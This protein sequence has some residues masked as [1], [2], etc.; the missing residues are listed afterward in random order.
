M[1]A[2]VLAAWFYF[3]FP[4]IVA[5][6]NYKVSFH[7]SISFSG[8][9]EN[10]V[11]RE[12]ELKNITHFLDFSTSD[13]RLVSIV[14]GPG[15]GKSALAKSV[16]HELLFRGVTIYYVDMAEV[17]SMQAL[18][19]KVLE[20]DKGIVTIRSITVDRMYKWARLLHY[21]T[22]LLLDNCDDMMN[23]EHE[24]EKLQNVVEELLT[25][26]YLKILS[27]SRQVTMLSIELTENLRINP[28]KHVTSCTLIKSYFCEL[29]EKQCQNIGNLTG[30]VPLAVKVV[31]SLLKFTPDPDTIIDRLNKALIPTLSTKKLPVKRRIDSCINISYEYLSPEVKKIGHCLVYFSGSFTLSTATRVC[32]F[33]EL[34]QLDVEHAIEDLVERSLLYTNRLTHSSGVYS[35]RRNVN[36][37]QFHQLIKAFFVHMDRSAEIR[38]TFSSHFVHFF[39]TWSLEVVKTDYKVALE[40][41]DQERHNLVHF[42]QILLE[43]KSIDFK[44]AFL[45]IQAVSQLYEAALLQY[46]FTVSEFHN[47]IL[48]MVKYLKTHCMFNNEDCVG[49]Y[50]SLVLQRANVIKDEYGV[51]AAIEWLKSHQCK[52]N[53]LQKQMPIEEQSSLNL[54]FS[55]LASLHDNL[56]DYEEA[57][58]YHHVVV[59]AGSKPD[60]CS[61]AT[62]GCSYYKLDNVF[63]SIKYLELSLERDD[64]DPIYKAEV[65][66]TLYNAHSDRRKGDQVLIKLVGLIPTLMLTSTMEIFKNF[67]YV[68]NIVT[69]LRD[70]GY[71]Y[72]SIALEEKQLA[73]LSNA[74][75]TAQYRS[76]VLP[77]A[78]FLT[79]YF[80]N[81]SKYSKCVNTAHSVLKII[82]GETSEKEEQM[83]LS[84][85]KDISF[86]TIY[87]GNLS[88]ALDS[89]EVLI[90]RIHRLNETSK[91]ADALI[92]GCTL[93]TLRGSFGCLYDTSAFALTPLKLLYSNR[94]F[95]S[96]PSWQMD[97]L[98]YLLIHFLSPGNTWGSTWSQS[99]DLMLSL[100][101]HHQIVQYAS[102]TWWSFWRVRLQSIVR[103]ILQCIFRVAL[104]VCYVLKMYYYLSFV[105]LCTL[106]CLS[107][108]LFTAAYFV[109][110]AY[111]WRIIVLLYC[112][113]LVLF[114]I[115]F[116]MGTFFNNNLSVVFNLLCGH[117]YLLFSFTSLYAAVHKQYAMFICLC[118]LT[119]G[120]QF[121]IFA[122]AYCNIIIKVLFNIP[123][124]FLFDSVF[125]MIFTIIYLCTI[126][127]YP[128]FLF[129]LCDL[130]SLLL[131]M[132]CSIIYICTLF[133]VPPYLILILSIIHFFYPILLYLL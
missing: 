21:N 49:T 75:F 15:F 43:P 4:N 104:V 11:G 108:I 71:Y 58:K 133:N 129:V 44:I 22:L 107:P 118:I 65:L 33:S 3:E 67:Y 95:P 55:L 34:Q 42:L 91:H 82:I 126:S 45:G 106:H 61:Y 86:C 16:A 76:S 17:S 25:S 52:V 102:Q 93:L 101:L 48:V 121:N 77:K 110:T 88:S 40:W 31:A 57:K 123:W 119:N 46:R 81:T 38:N 41:I 90:G 9:P 96:I 114:S 50:V 6:Y 37:Y 1:L 30:N 79:K 73:A 109:H 122:L 29:T 64:L 27:T 56:G 94:I 69:F 47:T 99:T 112:Q 39:A 92:M 120:M 100:P 63:L 7:R 74:T 62:I 66:I 116:F 68:T 32:Y 125:I 87:A 98:D 5:C 19:E 105:F 113:S 28:L 127:L 131:G 14:G 20:G 60:S 10:F 35:G 13:R 36:R 8:K 51:Q 80:Y 2:I 89:F 59:N 97:Y 70:K 103:G 128:S 12:Q 78:V 24:M 83:I 84:L 117:L 85:W 130:L 53:E 54:I 18:A 115:M 23:K 26:K 124:P 111:A 132:T 72:E